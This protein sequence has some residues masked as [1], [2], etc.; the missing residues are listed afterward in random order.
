[1][2]GRYPPTHDARYD[3]RDRDRSRSPPRF[4]DRRPS[5]PYNPSFGQNSR[6]PPLGPRGRGGPPFFD[7]DSKG[8]PQSFAPGRDRPFRDFD[9]DRRPRPPSPQGRPRSPPRNFRDA[10]SPRELEA[11]RTRRES[12]DGPLSA[13]AGPTDHTLAFGGPGFPHGGFGSGFRGRGRG[14]GDFDS[15]ERFRRPT[16]DDRPPHFRPRSP[17]ARWGRSSS[18]EGRDEW[19]GDR[20]ERAEDDRWASRDREREPRD[21]R[22]RDPSWRGPVVGSRF[23]SRSSGEGPSRPPTPSQASQPQTPATERAPPFDSVRPSN[24]RRASISLSRGSDAV[25]PADQTSRP[26]AG[27]TRPRAA[28]PP[29]APLAPSV[30]AFGSFSF[31]PV[32]PTSNVWRPTPEARQPPSPKPQTNPAAPATNPSP[33]AA[34]SSSTTAAAT[35]SEVPIIQKPVPSAP[36]SQRAASLHGSPVQ[37]PATVAPPQSPKAQRIPSEAP[38]GPRAMEAA[39]SAAPKDIRHGRSSSFGSS[40]PPTGPAALRHDATPA[41]PAGPIRHRPSISGASSLPST[42]PSLSSTGWQQ[43]PLH[44]QTPKIPAN[45]AS[46]VDQTTPTERKPPTGPS[47]LENRSSRDDGR[48]ARSD[49]ISQAVPTGPKA[50]VAKQQSPSITSPRVPTAPKA[51]RA[52]WSG[53]RAGSDRGSFSLPRSHERPIVGQARVPPTAPRS[54]S[55]NQWRSP[56]FKE[57]VT[58]IKKDT[59]ETDREQS[60]Q[61]SYEAQRAEAPHE[62]KREPEEAKPVQPSE[63]EHR[64][65]GQVDEI[66]DPVESAIDSSSDDDDVMDLDEED[67]EAPRIRFERQKAKLESQ[68]VDLS[69]RAYRMVSPFEQIARIE[70]ITVN[71]LPAPGELTPE[72]EAPELE[73]E[74]ASGATSR[75]TDEVDQELLTPKEEDSE[76]VIM[77]GNDV[78]D[79]FLPPPRRK[80]SPEIIN[81]PH[82]LKSPMSPTDELRE[83]VAQQEMM[84]P[85]LIDYLK[86]IQAR[87]SSLELDAGDSYTESYKQWK[88]TIREVDAARAERERIERELSNDPNA[89]VDNTA[90]PP[91][92]PATES[93]RRLHKFSSE[94]DIQKVLKESEEMARQQRE[95]EEKDAQKARD[96][97]EKEAVVPPLMDDDL[98]RRTMF[99]N[100]NNHRQPSQL[101]AIF[102]FQPPPDDFTE[103][104]H[105]IFLQAYRER[106]K[107]W[108]EI[109]SLLPGRTYQHC[110]HYYYRHKWDGRFKETKRKS[111]KGMGRSRGGKVSTRIRGAA[112]MADLNRP[113]DDTPGESTATGRPRRA[114]AARG[115]GPSLAPQDQDSDNK[116]G[117]TTPV[118]RGNRGDAASDT[119]EKATRKRRVP[120]GDKSSKRLKTQP[121]SSAGQ[122]LS[123]TATAPATTS[124]LVPA[125]G[126][127]VSPVKAERDLQFKSNELSK[128]ERARIDEANLLAGL[129]AGHRAV[130]GDAVPVYHT[131]AFFPAPRVQIPELPE[132]VRPLPTT[133]SA[134]RQAASS[135][136]SVPEQQDFLKFLG[137]YGTDFVAIAAQMGTKT[138]IMV[139]NHYQRRL[140]ADTTGEYLRT[141]EEANERRSRGEDLGPAPMPT[142]IVKRRYD[143]TPI[144]TSRPSTAQAD[145][146]EIDDIAPG[147]ARFVP[148][149]VSTPGQSRAAPVPLPSSLTSGPGKPTVPSSARGPQS[150]GPRMG[151][152]SDARDSRPPSQQ[153]QLQQQPSTRPPPQAVQTQLPPQHA[154]GPSSSQQ[155][156]SKNINPAWYQNLVLEQERAIGLQKEQEARVSQDRV[157]QV[158]HHPG[159]G[160]VDPQTTKSGEVHLKHEERAP[161]HMPSMFPRPGSASTRNSMGSPAP[162]PSASVPPPMVPPIHPGQHPSP[163]KATGF[164]PSSVPAGSPVVPPLQAAPPPE[165]RK[166]K[167][168]NILSILNSEPAEDHRA[169]KR[170]SDHNMQRAQSPANVQRHPTPT[171]TATSQRRD[172]IGT[173]GPPRGFYDK[174]TSSTPIPGQAQ[175]KYESLWSSIANVRRE[176]WPPRQGGPAPQGGSPNM[177]AL[178]RDRAYFQHRSSGLASIGNSA[179]GNPSPPPH[180][181]SHLLHG[182]H[183]RTS[184]FSGPGPMQNQQPPPQ[185]M[186]QYP[187]REQPGTLQ[188]HY[189]SASSGAPSHLSQSQ[190]AQNSP[191]PPPLTYHS[192]RQS[193]DEEYSRASERWSYHQERER[194]AYEREREMERERERERERDREAAYAAEH[195]RYR[196]GPPSLSQ[197][198]HAPLQQG[199]PGHSS[200]RDAPQGPPSGPPLGAFRHEERLPPGGPAAEVGRYEHPYRDPRDREPPPFY[201]RDRERDREREVREAEFVREQREREEYMRRNGGGAPPP[202]SYGGG[203]PPPSAMHHQQQQQQ[204]QMEEDHRRRREEEWAAREGYYRTGSVAGGMGYPPGPPPPQQQQ[205][206]QQQQPPPPPQSSAPGGLSGFR[207]GHPGAAPGGPPRR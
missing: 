153:Q 61:G 38:R 53:P 159:Y 103:D 6:N 162:A 178:D 98:M 4:T 34:A 114:A 172:T 75:S 183:S 148:A 95:K 101:I 171:G 185:Q 67:F 189:S 167:T 127:T 104:E 37:T 89:E 138:H 87:Q 191:N 195:A 145:T 51:D 80:D 46:N 24:D 15:R 143:N 197:P 73:D 52:S 125:L 47:F 7:G 150:S 105:E 166:A 192:R 84:K 96:A 1:M 173:S 68:L 5:G 179:R 160:Q 70:R 90:Y 82:L 207:H 66:G 83:H 33:N 142:P 139:K 134:S 77:E 122:S 161:L 71:D 180:G 78:L 129:Q 176:E 19:R 92:T 158:A 32:G 170:L 94:Y 124:P 10:L 206:Q 113:E 116:N 59:N 102:G 3:P 76:D 110:I 72:V 106:P 81:L 44:P 35:A 60:L 133:T 186:S 201:A 49:T 204:Q 36:K 30:P 26:D 126:S 174:P 43:Q 120:A 188:A 74:D 20:P 29:Q 175:P 130:R 146:P 54:A 194:A 23:D 9:R 198:M 187:P 128:E 12:R 56:G 118:R 79:N 25:D 203:A 8:P 58:S 86:S 27:L 85:A 123:T 182:R 16:L 115:S 112:L 40:M 165:P 100:S 57:P 41:F 136:W 65:K 97:L 22:D 200:I 169:A 45:D 140:E 39:P 135:Y 55:W 107:K 93:S 69:D 152:F 119:T 31:K 149:G 42:S 147:H 141:A 28:S 181:H 132:R 88:A 11:T 14:R 177:T 18:R 202:M 205:Q 155:S 193:R 63:H 164:R 131:E 17:P 151:F 190:P 168:S 121:S 48:I 156:E 111:R 163:P 108:G 137:Y 199:P 2:T 109:A 157:P 50:D 99:K 62:A 13:D 117:A 21:V 184:S 154:P 91:E 144:S 64:D 196:G